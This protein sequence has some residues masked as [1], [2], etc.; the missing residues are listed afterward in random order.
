MKVPSVTTSCLLFGYGT[1]VL[2]QGLAT[3]ARSTLFGSARGEKFCT[4]D[5]GGQQ[6][7]RIRQNGAIS[8]DSLLR[9]GLDCGTG[10]AVRIRARLQ[11]C[12]TGHPKNRGFSRWPVLGFTVPLFFR[13]ET[14]YSPPGAA[15][16]SL[17]RNVAFITTCCV[18][19]SSPRKRSNN[20]AAARAPI[21]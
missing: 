12:R 7:D 9:Y 18:G 2:S 14:P 13:A 11:A 20:S 15:A 10:W 17:T 21:W 4:Y 8:G 6:S 16:E 5:G 19:T 3:G 1:S